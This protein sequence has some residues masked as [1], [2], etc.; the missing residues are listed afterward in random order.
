MATNYPFLSYPT[1]PPPDPPLFKE[2]AYDFD[3]ERMII[4][5]GRT[6]LLSGLEALK[7]WIY[8]AIMT[9]KARYRAYSKKFGSEVDSLIGSTYSPAATL[10]EAQRMITEALMQSR[11]IKAVEYVEVSFEGDRLHIRS[12]LSTV[13]GKTTIDRVL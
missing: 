8:K 2:W 1:S 3:R 13:Y 5:D 6:V 4:Q 12:A 9:E 11:Y 10:A 7:V